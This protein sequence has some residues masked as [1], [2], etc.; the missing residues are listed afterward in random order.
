M[1][2]EVVVATLGLPLIVGHIVG[3]FLL[4]G[5]VSESVASGSDY[6]I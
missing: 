3:A 6:T 5:G 2:W 1:L 4:S